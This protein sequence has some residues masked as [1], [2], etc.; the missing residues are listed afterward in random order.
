MQFSRQCVISVIAHEFSTRRQLLHGRKRASL[1]VSFNKK[2]LSTRQH[3]G[4]ARACALVQSYDVRVLSDFSSGGCLSN[5]KKLTTLGAPR[6][7]T[8]CWRGWLSNSVSVC[9]SVPQCGC[10]HKIGF[11]NQRI[12]ALRK[13][14]TGGV[15]R[16]ARWNR[17][18][19]WVFE[20]VKFEV[21]VLMLFRLLSLKL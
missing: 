9:V 2:Q 1:I 21:R 19:E 11:Q 6:L 5:L 16:V 17:G 15:L 10:A 12:S 14:W 8:S 7:L 3:R 18:F 4:F 13:S 20:L